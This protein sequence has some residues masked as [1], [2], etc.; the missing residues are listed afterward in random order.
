MSIFAVM[1]ISQHR[2]YS[3]LIWF[4]SGFIF[5]G[6]CIIS[7]FSYEVIADWYVAR[8]PH[9][10]QND[11]W[12]TETFTPSALIVA[13]WYGWSLV[14]VSC[15]ILWKYYSQKKVLDSSLWNFNSFS[16]KKQDIIIFF[17]TL[18]ISGWY[19]TKAAYA[20]DEVFSAIHFAQQPFLQAISQY[21]LPNNHL[22]FNAINHLFTY[23]TDDLV[24]TGR[25]LSGVAVSL[26]MVSIYRFYGMFLANDLLK[27]CLI[28]LLISIFPII[29]FATQ[30]RGYG[31]HMLLGWIVFFNMY[32][33]HQKQEAKYLFRYELAA[34]LG[35]WTMPSFLYFWLGMLFPTVYEMIKSRSIDRHW[36][37]S[38][39]KIVWMTLILY[40]PAILFSGWRAIV[41]NKYVASGNESYF[42]FIKQ[43][44]GGNYLQG[45]FDEWFYTGSWFWLGLV[46]FIAPFILLRF[47]RYEDRRFQ[48]LSAYLISAMLVLLMMIL[49][50]KKI[51]F[52]RNLVSHC[53]LFWV[54]F[55]LTFVKLFITNF[56]RYLHYLTLCVVVLMGYFQMQNFNKF[57]F[58]LYY[59]DVNGWSTSLH[60]QNLTMLS[61]KKVF[62][63]DESFYWHTPVRKVTK[64]IVIGGHIDSTS[65]FLI[66]K[67]GRN[68][69][70]DTA[71]WS[72]LQTIGESQF[73][74]RHGSSH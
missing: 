72:A 4:L 59:Y 18:G 39:F 52:Y 67:E 16:I 33:Y 15:F 44:F 53:V 27:T 2:F 56:P 66:I 73:W 57:P 30:A 20:N 28:L 58:Q 22:F 40:F 7:F 19:Q 34:V 29:G 17:V 45:L 12:S 61:G 49:L 63:E 26:M 25:W 74:I 5:F 36:V 62:I 9:F 8:Y 60:E 11:I 1:S 50:M 47:F 65:H 41:S 70:V 35:L 42:T 23:F 6:S 14:I 13:R 37:Y 43:F 51:P 68:Y 31:L 54:L 38:G 48:S 32:L 71:I 55:L 64:N 46:I 10:Y 3:F 21:P 24:L 69:K